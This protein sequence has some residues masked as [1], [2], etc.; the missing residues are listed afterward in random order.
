MLQRWCFVMMSF[1]IVFSLLTLGCDDRTCDNAEP[2]GPIGDQAGQNDIKDAGPPPS[3]DDSCDEE[4]TESEKDGGPLSEAAYKVLLSTGIFVKEA[5]LF[6]TT[7]HEGYNLNFEITEDQARSLLPTNLTPVP[8]KLLET[9][10]EPA[11]YLSWYMAVLDPV[12]S[13]YSITRIDLFT[14]AKNQNGELALQFVSSFMGVPEAIGS[15]E[16]VLALFKEIFDFF[17]RDSRTGEAAYPH[18]YTESLIADHDTFKLIYE[19]STIEASACEPLT[20]GERFTSEF[21]AANSQIYRN[22]IDKNVNYFNQSFINVNVETRN[23]DCITHKNLKGFHPLLENL[24]SIHFYGSKDKDIV[25]YYE[26]CTDD[27]C[28]SPFD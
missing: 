6:T 28:G 9:D 27:D 25:W 26:M 1:G 18:Y 21:V 24:K 5:A 20:V 16:S 14:Y 8:L 17:A 12:E 4:P 10:P 11:Y 2:D 23:P 7:Y 15:D 13:S 19:D 22:E 3:C